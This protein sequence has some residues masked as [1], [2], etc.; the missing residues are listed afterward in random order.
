[1]N[2]GQGVS[3]LQQR[4]TANRMPGGQMMMRPG[5]SMQMM[6]GRGPM[7]GGGAPPNMGPMMAGARGPPPMYSPHTM[8][9]GGSPANMGMMGHS[10]MDPNQ[11]IHSPAQQQGM[12]SPARHMVPSPAMSTVNTP[13]NPNDPQ[14]AAAQED[15]A[16]LEKV[17][18]MGKYIEPLHKTIDRIGNEDQTKL[19][20]MKSLMNIL[21]NHN[22]RIP[23]EALCKCELVLI[24]ILDAESS[25]Q[26]A[27]ESNVNPLFEAIVSLRAKGQPQGQMNHVLQKTFGAPLESIYGTEI[28]L[29]PLPKKRKLESSR[30]TAAATSATTGDVPD[31]VQGEI[32]RLRS[33]FK[34]N[35]DPAQPVPKSGM[36]HLTCQLED[37]N[38]PSVPPL[39]VTLPPGYPFEASPSCETEMTDYFATSF[40]G[41]VQSALDARLSK[42]PSRYTLSQLLSAWEMS[43]RAACSPRQQMAK[44]TQMSL[45]MG[46]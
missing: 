33:Q 4:L 34:V 35:L 6:G 14:S 9:Q 18:Q 27:A 24:K 23:M 42:M 17:R 7:M 8:N 26:P 21:T 43:V 28:S 12:G 29:P 10:P 11:Y 31:I 1:M 2:Q 25:V 41:L 36:V 13:Q 3:Q 39:S 32:A 20:K 19:E 40:L 45:F 46:L 16:Y 44:V 15:Q 22:K 30:E 38:L 37:P 5:M